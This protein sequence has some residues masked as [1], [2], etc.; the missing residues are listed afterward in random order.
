MKTIGKGRLAEVR[1]T[2]TPQFT[3]ERG[4]L[5][6]AEGMRGI[7]FDVKRIFWLYDIPEGKTRAGHAHKTCWQAIVAVHGGCDIY[8]TDGQEET[9][10]SLSH[11]TTMVSIPPGIWC[12][13]RNITNDAVIM[14][15]ASEHF[16][17]ED[18]LQPYSEFIEWVKNSNN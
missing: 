10:L 15:A 2:D 14:V 8:L 1:V 7:P 18:Y 3:D 6:V 13:L 5:S 17:P 9:T 16:D 11:P 12:E 4:S